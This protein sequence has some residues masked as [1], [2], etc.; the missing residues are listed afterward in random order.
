MV[1]ALRA[2]CAGAPGVKNVYA[3]ISWQGRASACVQ[4]CGCIRGSV[5]A[6][7]SDPSAMM[8]HLFQPFPVYAPISWQRRASASV[9]MCR[10]TQGSV[11]VMQSDPCAVM[12]HFC[13]IPLQ[14]IHVFY[15]FD[16]CL[17]A[18]RCAN[19]PGAQ[20]CCCGRGSAVPGVDSMGCAV[21]PEACASE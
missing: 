13:S 11:T 15:S 8:P 19:A 10:C 16:V 18:R 4:I 5:V 1:Y 20:W 6:M 12:P 2:R 17:L 14:I 3:R 21:G 9:Q 7:Q